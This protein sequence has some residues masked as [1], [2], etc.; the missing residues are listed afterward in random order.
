MQDNEPRLYLLTVRGTPRQ[1]L[2]ASR[3]LHNET[4]GADASVAAA[5]A[6]GDLSHGVYTSL[7]EEPEILFI[8][9][10][11]RLDGLG[12]FFENPAV[13]AQA[14]QMFA[15]RDAVV[16]QAAAGYAG[17]SLPEP[18][19]QTDR[20]IGII[21]GEVKS[22]DSARAIL[23]KGVIGGINEARKLGQ[24]SHAVYAPVTPPGVPSREI[25]GVD[26][27]TS[28]DG[29]VEYYKQPHLTA[30][31]DVFDGRPATSL[32]QRAKGQWREW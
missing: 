27:W 4:A 2:E 16:W 14:G 15:A 31:M 7:A 9:F 10:W 12:Q 6:L 13:Q 18:A 24:L 23:N 8:D 3:R 22:E 28:Q 11:N 29:M 26:V 17:F 19:G 21:R 32:W 20:F 1:T 30:L 5:R 25:L